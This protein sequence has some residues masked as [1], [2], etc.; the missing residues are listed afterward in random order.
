MIPLTNYETFK[1]GWMIMHLLQG[2]LQTRKK[3]LIRFIVRYILIPELEHYRVR[4]ILKD[5]FCSYLANRKQFVSVDNH[6]S[7]I[8]TILTEVS[9]GSVLG[10]LLFLIY[11]NDLHNC[12]KHSRTYHFADDT[13]IFC[14]PQQLYILANKVNHDLKNLSQKLKANKLP[15][16]FKKTELIIF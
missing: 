10:P 11:I 3:H 14:T 2:D 13:N 9:Q 5:C 12:I 15:L 7:T 8:Q 6:N 4:D 1:L 16:N